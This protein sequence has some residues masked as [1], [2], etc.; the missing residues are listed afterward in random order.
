MK[1]KKTWLYRMTTHT[2]I[3]THH[4]DTQQS[5]NTLIFI[6][7]QFPFISIIFIC[8]LVNKP[9][10]NTI[11]IVINWLY[12]ILCSNFTFLALLSLTFDGHCHIKIWKWQYLD[13]CWAH[14]YMSNYKCRDVFIVKYMNI[15]IKN[16]LLHAKTWRIDCLYI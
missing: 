11:V 13:H 2:H 1:Y 14:I 16:Y 10:D 3:Y 6:H 9:V 15:S 5:V 4:N 7:K 8:P 12:S